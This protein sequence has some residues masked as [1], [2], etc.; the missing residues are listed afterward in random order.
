MKIP[1]TIQPIISRAWFICAT[2]HILCKYN[3]ALIVFIHFC[4][5]LKY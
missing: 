5:Q 1:K 3:V 4:F 2:K